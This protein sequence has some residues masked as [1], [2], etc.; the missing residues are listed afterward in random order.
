MSRTAPAR[1]ITAS[2]TGVGK[3]LVAAALTWQLRRRGTAAR[4]L[5]PVVS[6]F[7]DRAAARS[8]SGRLLSAQNTPVT[9]ETVAAISPWRFRAP[10]SPDM[11]AARE[12]RVI[13]FDALV[14]FCN[15]AVAGAE[16]EGGAVL[17][18]GVGGVMAPLTAQATVVDW[19]AALDVPAVLVVGSYLGALSHALT[20]AAVLET[21]RVTLDAVIVSQSARSPVPLAE[22]VATLRRF[23]AP[24]KL[25]AV[26]RIA[27]RRPR[28][29][30]APDLTAV[31]DAG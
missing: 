30:S 19:I 31:L 25:I 24:A 6:G 5:K 16:R 18:E 3:T 9:A 12:G 23:L 13:E 10:L 4:A 7:T 11:A 15:E 2:G 17:I 29:K 22:T 14:G 27:G 26:E 28:W 21:R 1:F 20:A 8:D